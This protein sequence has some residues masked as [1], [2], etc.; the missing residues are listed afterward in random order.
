MTPLPLADRPVVLVWRKRIWRCPE[1]DCEVATW[2]EDADAIA[3]RAV[4]TERARAEI[5]RRVGRD[6]HSVGSAA[7]DKLKGAGLAVRTVFRDRRRCSRRRAHSIA[8]SLRRRSEESKG[9]AKAI[10]G[11]LAAIAAKAAAEAE[12]VVRNARRALSHKEMAGSGRMRRILDELAVTVERT[13]RIVAQTRIRLS[14]QIPDGA[15]RLVSLHDPD[16]R[17]LRK[18]RLDRPTEFGYTAQ[19][20]D[21]ADGVVVDHELSVGN[22]PDAPR[23]AP[24]VIRIKA[25][26]GKAPNTRDRRPRLRRGPSRGAAGR[27]RRQEHGDPSQGQTASR[28]AGP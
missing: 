26:T 11:E 5:C 15:T 4:L 19:V 25:R 14:G 23:L 8:A 21:N 20:V 28:P 18:G 3:P 27:P 17:P 10:T 16:A 22:P 9:A 1:P 12:G 24:A 13:R 2:S 7:V 6:G